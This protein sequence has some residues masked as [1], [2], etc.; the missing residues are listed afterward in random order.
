[1]YNIL[2]GKVC[3]LNIIRHADNLHLRRRCLYYGYLRNIYVQSV[4]HV[5][6]YAYTRG[7][8]SKPGDNTCLPEESYTHARTTCN[9]PGKH[10]VYGRIKCK[11][12]QI[13]PVAYVC[14]T[15]LYNTVYTC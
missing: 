9:L 8:W 11:R 12:K 15:R 13:L 3:T 4:Y 6:L 14:G 5:V 1:M 10:N 2:L 7:W